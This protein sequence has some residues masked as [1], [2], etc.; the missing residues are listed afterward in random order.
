MRYQ[1]DHDL[2]IHTHLS[3]CS[4]DEGQ[5]PESILAHAK[6]NGLKTVCITDHYWDDAVPCHTLVNWWY[7]AQNY[8]H[9]SQDCPMPKDEEVQVLFGCETD[10]DSDN[11]VGIPRERWN[12]FGFIIISTTH[13]HHMCGPEWENPSPLDRARLWVERLEAVLN[14]PLPFGKVGIAH[15]A[16]GL[17]D[18]HSREGYLETLRLIPTADMERLFTKAAKL[19]VG[20]ELNFGDMSFAEEEAETVLRMFRI[21]KAC[22]CKFY[23]GSDA[24]TRKAFEGVMEIFERAITLLDLQGSDKFIIKNV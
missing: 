12:D 23:F 14:T 18:I 11:K 17:I 1:I 20:I 9:I 4:D 6:K 22:G 13:F 10:L 24:H 7:E 15:L 3:I 21:A 8:A 19:G 16:C 5:N 2:H